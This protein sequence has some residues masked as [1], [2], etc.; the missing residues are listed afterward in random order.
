MAHESGHSLRKGGSSL[1]P[2]CSIGSPSCSA[3]KKGC[4][5]YG[6]SAWNLKTRG[7]K[8]TLFPSRLSVYDGLGV[9][10]PICGNGA[11][12]QWLGENIRKS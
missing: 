9:R 1:Q 8:T 2:R 12:T 10:N 3:L 6:I 11:G 4:N 5:V 7:G